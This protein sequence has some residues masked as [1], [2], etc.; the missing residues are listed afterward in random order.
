MINS[1]LLQV[2]F[3]G[4]LLGAVY[5]AIGV[6]L[7]LIFG[8]MRIVTFCHGEFLM[9][10]LYFTFASVTWLGL[11]SYASIIIVVP[12]M[13]L[14]AAAVYYVIIE[15]V[16]SRNEH[17]QIVTTL[18]F[19]LVLQ[20]LALMI[21]TADMQTIPSEFG[22]S[23]IRLS[24]L[25]VRL[26]VAITACVSVLL[27]VGL[28]WV[29]HATKIGRQIR[30]TSQDKDA[31]ALCGVHVDRVYLFA[32]CVGL[33]VLSIVAVLLAPTLYVSPLIGHSYTLTAFVIVVLG[34]LG[35]FLGAIIGGFIVGLV[36][37]IGGLV[38]SGSMPFALTF[39]LFTIILLFRPQGL[40]GSA[41]L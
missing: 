23:T 7:T 40:F 4:L 34:S 10:A 20:N 27:C 37:S 16:L 36:E 3:D 11:N 31:A 18:A 1:A 26:P 8:V 35:N 29:L 39:G 15:P 30:A 14:F 32:F 25:I 12:A 9:V 2:A 6:T 5:A 19:G 22:T 21:F 33:G 24:S 28:G 38:T 41:R 17:N 13:L